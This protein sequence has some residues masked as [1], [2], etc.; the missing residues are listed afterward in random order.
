MARPFACANA[1][2]DNFLIVCAFGDFDVCKVAMRADGVNAIYDHDTTPELRFQ[3]S[4]SGA[5]SG[6]EISGDVD[7]ALK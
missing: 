6:V 5:G 3:G 2:F 7:R 4:L 1:F